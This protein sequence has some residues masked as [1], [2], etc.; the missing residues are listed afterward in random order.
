[1]IFRSDG[2]KFDLRGSKPKGSDDSAISRFE[3]D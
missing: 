2:R 1:M 3:T